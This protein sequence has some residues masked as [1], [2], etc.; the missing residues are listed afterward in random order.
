MSGT[1]TGA[2]SVPAFT[3]VGTDAPV[4]IDGVCEIPGAGVD[5]ET[6]A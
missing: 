3:M 6:S 4:C 1:G 2:A 5:A